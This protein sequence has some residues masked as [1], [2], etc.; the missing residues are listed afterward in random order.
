MWVIPKK[1]PFYTQRYLEPLVHL[2][3]STYNLICTYFRP[4]L[5]DCWLFWK[6]FSRDGRDRD[7]SVITYLFKIMAVFLVLCNKKTPAVILCY[8][9]YKLSIN[10]LFASSTKCQV[11]TTSL[12]LQIIESPSLFWM[13]ATSQCTLTTAGVTAAMYSKP[14]LRKTLLGHYLWR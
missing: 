6:L 9:R 10:T 1:A 12:V 13:Q 7:Q 8:D 14:R 2:P 5:F 4:K 3:I 11:P